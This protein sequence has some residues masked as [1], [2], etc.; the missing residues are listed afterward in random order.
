MA[1]LN[2][3]GKI[4]PLLGMLVPVA[5]SSDFQG[6]TDTSAELA[7]TTMVVTGLYVFTCDVDCYVKQ[8]ATPTAA[9]ADGSMLVPAGMPL[10]IDGA[11]GAE[12]AVIR[13]GS[14]DGVCTLQRVALVS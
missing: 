5:G 2:R 7:G 6:V 3:A 1:D 4:G 12:L 11:Q 9:A 13:K 14:S 8:G 10:L